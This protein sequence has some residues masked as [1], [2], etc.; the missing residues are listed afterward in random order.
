MQNM[1]GNRQAEHPSNACV[2][3]GWILAHVATETWVVS[4]FANVLVGSGHW[5][6]L[7]HN[8]AAFGTLTIAAQAL[9][10]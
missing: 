4:G 6:A 3:V 9:H 7:C 1:P 2:A 8:T 10:L 5:S